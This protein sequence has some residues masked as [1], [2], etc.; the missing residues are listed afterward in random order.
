MLTII[1]GAGA[2]FD[3]APVNSSVDAKRNLWRPPLTKDLFLA[4]QEWFVKPDRL[5]LPHN[6]IPILERIRRD[7]GCV[8]LERSL[9]GLKLEIDSNP[10]R[11]PQLLAVQEWLCRVLIFCTYEWLRPLAGATTL[12]DLVSRLNDWCVTVNVP[13]SF[14]TFNYDL[15]L[16]KA[17]DQCQF[18]PTN[19]MGFDLMGFDC[20]LTNRF[21]IFK[22]HG[23][24]DWW[25]KVRFDS[26]RTDIIDRP[27]SQAEQ[28]SL[29]LFVNRS[30]A[31]GSRVGLE[32]TTKS[33][34]GGTFGVLPAVAIPVVSKSQSDFIFPPGHG[35]KMLAALDAT[36]AMLVV[37]WAAAEQHFMEEVAARVSH[38]IPVL[39]V[40]GKNGGA[41]TSESLRTAG[42]L[43]NIVDSNSGFS[44]FLNM[45]Q[46]EKWLKQCM[47]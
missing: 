9:E 13:I 17:I 10:N 32:G 19:R 16:E 5:T 30:S 18:E 37:G 24:V 45:S 41:A 8:G 46:L 12:V 15:L 43:T 26:D 2:S 7:S 34:D 4:S 36:T 20:Y 42:K 47:E 27:L 31:G 25:W 39:I 14:I 29:E 22:P 11:W 21:S 40:C 23:S 33:T 3:S 28:I 38:E 35:D 1:L 6:L 44:D